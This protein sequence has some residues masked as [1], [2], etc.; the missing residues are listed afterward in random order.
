[1][2]ILL[3]SNIYPTNDTNYSG[4]AVCHSFTK[5]WVAMGHNVRV[6]HYDSLFPR[7]Y[8]WA[9]ELFT[10]RIQ[11][12]TGAVVYTNTPRK[13]I[14]YKV[15]NIPVLFAPLRKLIPHTAPSQRQI[16]KAFEYVCRELDNE[17]FVPD[18]ITAHFVLPQL[19]FIP[20][21]KKKYPNSKTCLVPHGLSDEFQIYSP[22]Q[23][24]E[25]MKSVD[26]FGFRS[27]AFKLDFEKTFGTEKPT[28]LCLSGIPEKY[29]EPVNRDFK[30]GVK[31]FAFVGSLLE[32]KNVDI[33]LKALHKA[34]K[35]Y[36][37]TFDI[38]GSGAENDKL[39][40]IVEEFNIGEHVVFHGQKKRDEAQQIVK[41]ADC[42]IMVSSREAFGLVYVEAMAKG[43]IVI[44]TKGQGIDGVV[45]NGENGFL[46]KAG[47]VDVLA[48]L[49]KY[50]V[51]LPKE[52]LKDISDKAVATA[53]ELTDRKVAEHYLN[54]IINGQ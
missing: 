31:R 44:G 35:G 16:N 13:P 49:I 10:E 14:Q 30:G 8:Y 6:I 41:D 15:D 23:Y 33:T 43:C 29:I 46:C 51:D 5:E 27:L 37:Y 42:F 54:A 52:K 26:I 39:H 48:N 9:A 25:M 32:L 18:V 19:Q 45:I 4:T 12:K 7:P 20:L 28:F 50:I 2:N 40:R 11:A 53:S 22:K 21:F 3:L 24:R 47:D 38:V 36:D 17:G 1:M 34:M